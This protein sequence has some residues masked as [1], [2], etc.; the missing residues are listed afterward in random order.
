MK[1]NG[2]VYLNLWFGF[3][4]SHGENGLSSQFINLLEERRASWAGGKCVAWRW[5]PKGDV[6]D[7]TTWSPCQ[8]RGESQVGLPWILVT[9][10]SWLWKE[11]LLCRQRWLLPWLACFQTPPRHQAVKLSNPEKLVSRGSTVT[12][13]SYLSF[14][15]LFILFYLFIYFGYV[16]SS[17]LR[18][19]CR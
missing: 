12:W 17:L 5:S 1:G 10:T 19:G 13:T 16:G 6:K 18:A 9:W 4:S 3:L 14:F 15:F 8:I 7:Q 2:A 11:V